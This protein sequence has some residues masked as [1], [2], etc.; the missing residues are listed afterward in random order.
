MA[1]YF[2]VTSDKLCRREKK[3]TP[4]RDQTRRMSVMQGST[5]NTETHGSHTIVAD[6][7]QHATNWAKPFPHVHTRSLREDL[8]DDVTR[9]VAT[10]Q[11]RS[12]DKNTQ[13]RRIRCGRQATNGGE[14]TT[15]TS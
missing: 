12:G 1:L 11:K 10:I 5:R 8:V 15:T 2:K 3:R 6:E 7:P 13:R 9:M 4:Q 14:N